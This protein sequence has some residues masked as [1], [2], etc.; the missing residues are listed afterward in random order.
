MSRRE[1]AIDVSR[2]TLDRLEILAAL[3]TRWN[4]RVNLVSPGSIDELWKRHIWDSAQIA[5][6]S[7]RSGDWVDIGSGAGFPG[8]VV[9]ALLAERDVRRSV[10][11]VESDR[12]K[13]VFLNEAA[14]EM[15]L[16]VRVVASRIEAFQGETFDTISARA[17]APLPKLLDLA[18]PLLKSGGE[19]VFLKGREVDSELTSATRRWQMQVERIPSITGEDATILRITEPSFV[20]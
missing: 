5:D 2:E 10:V 11:L 9:A 6:I 19:M 16:A 12:R 20:S 15:G 18:V 7:Q 3:L 4:T 14:R 13:S 17:L 8:L 1:P